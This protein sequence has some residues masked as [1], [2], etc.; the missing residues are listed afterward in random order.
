MHESHGHSVAAWTGVTT[1]MIASA[2]LCAGVFFGWAWAI[3]TGI[4]L[5]VLG[6]MAW[7]GLHKAGYNEEAWDSRHSQESSTHH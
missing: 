7:W 3:W 6:V 1:L 4:A 2:L 5:T